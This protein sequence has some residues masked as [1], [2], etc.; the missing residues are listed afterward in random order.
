[1]ENQE[2]FDTWKNQVEDVELKNQIDCLRIIELNLSNVCNLKCPFCPQSKGWKG[3]PKYMSLETANTIANQLH[4]IDYKGY[5]CTAGFGEPLM[6]PYAESI[7]NI[8]RDFN[9]VVVSNG[10]LN[11]PELW[12]RLSKFAQIKISV[13]HWDQIDWYKDKFKNT[14]AWFRN[15]DIVNPQMNLYNRGGYLWEPKEK[16]TRMCNFPFYKLFIDVDGSYLQ[17]EADWAHKSKNQ[18]NIY[19]TSIEEYFVDI[20]ELD[21]QMMI[22]KGGRQNFSSCANCDIDGTLTGQKFVD[23]WKLRNAN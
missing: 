22:S 18:Y 20:M 19:N 23:F 13:H 7:L 9:L 2:Q 16:T 5:I 10:I 8:L 6:N 1:M 15:H 4:K 17:C 21:R 11:K 3:E 12:E 14:N